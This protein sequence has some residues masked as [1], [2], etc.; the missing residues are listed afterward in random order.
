MFPVL[1]ESASA[2]GPGF[3]DIDGISVS[4]GET[5]DMGLDP[6][7]GRERGWLS[8]GKSGQVALRT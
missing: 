5:S 4:G 6:T 7:A 3:P 2:T 8:S 1:G